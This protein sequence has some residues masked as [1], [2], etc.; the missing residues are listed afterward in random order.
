MSK[1]PD[2]FHHKLDRLKQ[3]LQEIRRRKMIRAAVTYLVAAWVLIEVSSVVVDAFN[4]P[5]IV[6]QGLIGLAILGLPFAMALAWIYDVTARGI[7]RTADATDEPDASDTSPDEPST[8]SARR[9]MTMLRASISVEASGDVDP[10]D[11]LELQPAAMQVA[12]KV[13]QRYGGQLLAGHGSEILAYFGYPVAAEDDTYR[14]VSAALGLVEGIDRIEHTRAA[15]LNVSVSCHAAVHTGEVITEES[16]VDGDGQPEIFGVL[17]GTAAALLQKGVSD[18]VLITA[19]TEHIVHGWFDVQ[20]LGRMALGETGEKDVFQVL[21]VSGARNRLEAIPPEELTPLVGRDAELAILKQGWQRVREGQG[22]AFMISGGAGIGKSRIA[23]A[24]R[25]LAAED[26]SAWLVDVVCQSVHQNT[27]L[28]PIIDYLR[29]DALRFEAGAS[30]DE[31]LNRIEGLLAEFNQDLEQTV[32]LM[33]GLLQ[34]PLGQRYRPPGSS[35]QVQRQATMDLLINLLTERS[36]RQPVLFVLED[37]HWADPTTIDLLNQLFDEVPAHALMVAITVRTPFESPWPNRSELSQINLSGLDAEAVRAVCAQLG[38]DLPTPVLAGIAAKADGVPLFIEEVTRSLVQSKAFEDE[39]SEAEMQD[40]IEALVPSSIQDALTARLDHLGK[41]RRLALLGAAVGREFTGNLILQL[42]DRVQIRNAGDLLEQLVGA[43]VL[44]RR[45]RGDRARYRF[46][47]A[48]IQDAAYRQLL[49][50]DRTKYHREIASLLEADFPEIKIEQP[51][52]LALHYTRADRGEAAVPLWLAAGRR[53]AR[54]SADLEAMSHFQR[55][56][57]LLD[58]VANARE[59]TQLELELQV[60][61]GPSLMATHGYSASEVEAAYE[62]AEELCGQVGETPRLIPVLGGL[63][64]YNQVCANLS[65]ALG[66]A[67]RLLGI[68]ESTQNEDVLLEAHVFLGVTSMHLAR[69]SDSAKHMQLAIELY[70]PKK[71]ASHAY[72]YGQDPGMAAH[73]YL[74]DTLW[75]QG[76]P[77]AARRE[78]ETAIAHARKLKHP[79]SLAFALAVAARMSVRQGDTKQARAWAT[80]ALEVSERNGFPVWGSMARILNAWTT[81]RLEGPDAGVTEMQQVLDGYREKGTYVSTA[82]YMGLLAELYGQQGRFDD[83]LA[84]I[85]EALDESYAED[86]H[87]EPEVLR[88]RGVLLEARGAADDAEHAEASYRKALKV[89]DAL[90]A[91]GWILKSAVSLARHL[92]N[93]DDRVE[94]ASTLEYALAKYGQE[95]RGPDL[96]DARS[97]LE[98]LST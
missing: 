26:S 71:H 75:L 89:G 53:A 60:A 32:P 68:A 90:G 64:A 11:L 22:Q 91:G 72:T 19:E 85:A 16:D 50:K 4:L 49:R 62:R 77:D 28:H 80:E 98:R 38:A 56:L 74:A 76:H 54:S 2:H 27:A 29:R 48:L 45:G 21:H 63:W 67:E 57:G 58:K 10:E 39:M 24:V 70:D 6:M 37:L 94:A 15:D 23:L 55:G 7:V 30:D 12:R 34:V 96:D 97:L 36:N 13:C 79:H 14:A 65:K 47:H 52:L 43:E 46:K 66:Y 82:Y 41:A 84:L 92:A 20:S 42:A 83:G 69:F 44:F 5:D 73:A 35:P 87:A 88:I 17:P 81:A 93:N 18:Q 59:R 40:R 3:F 61:M 9:H 8:R 31:R 1:R 51:E 86:R 95:E 33:A 25:E 78:A